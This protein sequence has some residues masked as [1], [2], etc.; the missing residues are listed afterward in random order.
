ML[1]SLA[2]AKIRGGDAPR[3]KAEQPRKPGPR[4]KRDRMNIDIRLKLDFFEHPKARKLRRRLGAD[5]NAA[6]GQL[7]RN[8][9][10]NQ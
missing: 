8:A 9:A 4:P 2:F 3:A 10:K 6:C 5:V 1:L 7:R